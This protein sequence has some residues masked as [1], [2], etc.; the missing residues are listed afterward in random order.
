ML[1]DEGNEDG[2]KINKSDSLVELE[3]P[4]LGGRLRACGR[5]RGLGGLFERDGGFVA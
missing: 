3:F 2:N 4:R 5:K 1:N